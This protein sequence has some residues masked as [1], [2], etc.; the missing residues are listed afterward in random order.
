M[1]YMVIHLFEMIHS[2]PEGNSDAVWNLSIHAVIFVL[3]WYFA[4]RKHLS[5]T[6]GGSAAAETTA[7]EQ[8]NLGDNPRQSETI[9]E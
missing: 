9:N 1:F 4:L 7:E 6:L 3:F 8:L 5:V 2:A